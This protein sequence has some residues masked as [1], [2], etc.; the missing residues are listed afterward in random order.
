MIWAPQGKWSL[1][2]S[3]AEQLLNW[4]WKAAW[5]VII[6]KIPVVKK[7]KFEGVLLLLAR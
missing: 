4:I 2:F 3:Q 6:A 5:E 1:Q 7:K